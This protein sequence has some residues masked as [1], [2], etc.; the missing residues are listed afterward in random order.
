MKSAKLFISALA[1]FVFAAAAFGAPNPAAEYA[2]LLGYEYRVE[3]GANGERGLV[4]PAP[5]VEYDAW[6]FYRGK[7]GN[8][9]QYGALFGYRTEC[10]VEQHGDCSFEYAVCIATGSTARAGE[11]ITLTDLMARNGQITQ[12]VPGRRH[13]ATASGSQ[14]THFVDFGMSRADLP[15]AFDWRSYEGRAY[16]GPVR[17]QG[18]CGSCYAFG[19][20]AAAEGSYNRAMGLFDENCMDFSESFIIWTLAR[21][22]AYRNH[23]YGCDG[24]DYDYAELQA[25][26][27]A[28]V[29]AEAVYPYQEADPGEALHLDK[30]R[31]AFG[32]WGRI[33]CSD[34]DAIKAAIMTYGVVDAAVNSR[35]FYSYSSGVYS[36]SNTDCPATPCHNTSTDHAISLV[37]WD[38]NPPEGGGGC[39]VLRN[40]WGSGWGEGGYMRIRYH[41]A[42]VACAACFL[43]QPGNMH[44]QLDVISSYGTPSPAAGSHAYI[45][46]A[47]ANCSMGGSPDVNGRTQYVCVGWS[48][49][50]DAPAT[51]TTTNTGN[52]AISLASSITWNW[53][54]Q[55]LL[56]VETLGS[57]ALSYTGGW[58]V[59][60]SRV[61]VTA[62]PSTQGVF[63]T[64]WS[65]DIDDCSIEDNVIVAPMT[66]ARRIAAVFSDTPILAAPHNLTA[67]RGVKPTAVEL[68]WRAVAGATHY[69]VHR[70]PWPITSNPSLIGRATTPAYT[71]SEVER[72][73]RCA[74]WVRA[75]N[76]AISSGLSSSAVGWRRA[77]LNNFGE[78]SGSDLAVYNT[79]NGRWYICDLDVVPI[80]FNEPFGGNGFVPVPGDYDADGK[81]DLA[82]FNVLSGAWYIMGAN[83]SVLAW[84]EAWGWP[85]AIPVS[86]DYDGDGAS[87]LALFDSV[88]GRW[89]VKSATGNVLFFGEHWGFKGAVPVP[90]DYDGDSR[91]DFAVFEPNA[92]E[93]YIRSATNANVILAWKVPW[94]FKGAVPVPGDYNGDG[95]S[96]LAVLDSS[97]G[98]WFILNLRDEDVL[99]WRALWGFKGAV[100]VPGDYDDDG[101][102][103]MAVF[104][105]Q[106]GMWFI[107]SSGGDILA[108]RLLWGWPGAFVVGGRY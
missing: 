94:G 6:D 90:G 73:R 100:P 105:P 37:G 70:A 98:H 27:D 22:P 67:T 57:G 96:D 77:A 79:Q 85:G 23:F 82:L 11:S 19:A 41:A 81:A 87:D 16:I 91:S 5:G 101:M 75:H 30:P 50:G 7:V 71:D 74:Y 56:Q 63:F 83:G 39:W 40:S 60:D 59:L 51:G 72:G 52:F 78:S 47:I 93:W 84:S 66:S 34:I 21:Y 99:V 43:A 10:R 102:D 45:P 62:A 104:D 26:V 64:E 14:T 36:D 97:R 35:N 1:F 54:T 44:V 92:G 80:I 48:G 58:H 31:V 55:V 68:A 86:G 46:G 65:G 88:S 89:Y 108:W 25:L 69:T 29:C 9:H 3:R 103:D 32:Q 53:Q 106:T 13:S 17:D 12:E 107:L 20:L 33:G 95:A 76:D 2:W 61:V 8:E 49:S 28:G 15:A 42:R 24:S 18:N 38:D 4:S